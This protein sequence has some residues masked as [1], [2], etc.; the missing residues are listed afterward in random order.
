MEEKKRIY[1]MYFEVIVSSKDKNKEEVKGMIEDQLDDMFGAENY[2]TVDIAELTQD[3][4]IE[5]ETS[6]NGIREIDTITDERISDE[7]G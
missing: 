2:T 4:I 7:L 5:L 1:S 6:V 3:E